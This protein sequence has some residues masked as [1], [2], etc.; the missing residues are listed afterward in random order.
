MRPELN[1]VE[2]R[3]LG[4]LIEKGFTTPE[5]YPL[6]LNSIVVGSN[7]KSCRDPVS[8]LGEEA[9]LDSLE[10]L[11][12]KGLATLVRMEGS[13]VDRWRHHAGQPLGLGPKELAVL[14]ELLLR[15][16]QT[17]GELRGRSSRMVAIE[18]LEELGAILET[19]RSRQE[20]LVER[21]GP[22]GRRRGV[23]YAHTFY[24]A[25]E[26][27]VLKTPEAGEMFEEEEAPP[28]AAPERETAPET[29]AGP[30]PSTTARAWAPAPPA[31]LEPSPGAAHV[32][33]PARAAYHSPAA[34]APLYSLAPPGPGA[35]AASTA[36]APPPAAL[37]A[38]AEEVRAL[39]E[40]VEE[41]ESTFARFL[42]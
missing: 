3:V 39:R 36:A 13:R 21:L 34:S 38:L 6:S 25:S 12:R 15:G 9:V 30:E 31:P 22:P 17:D 41:L 26:R 27:S 5:Q 40:R 16:P 33:E 2:R 8:A 1:F 20:P 7:Q 37:A 11:R 28:P 29:A 4:V 24:S 10:G 23:K 42:H 14:A 19:L 18:T 32:H 35:G